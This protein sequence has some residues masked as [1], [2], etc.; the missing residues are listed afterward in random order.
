MSTFVVTNPSNGHVLREFNSDDGATIDTKLQHAKVAQVGWAKLSFEKRAKYVR[1]FQSALAKNADALAMTLTNET[2][3]PI[4]QARGEVRSTLGRIQYFLD[5]TRAFTRP[6]VVGPLSF[7][8]P[9]LASTEEWVTPCPL[10]VIANVSAWNYPYFVGTN[11]F[12]PALLTGNAV[13]YKPSEF[14]SMT[15]LAITRL[16]HEAGVPEHVFQ[17]VLG[18]GESGKALVNSNID[19]VF[20]T[21][22][23]A[24]GTAIARSLAGRCIPLQLELGGKDPTYVADD[25]DIKSAAESL[26]DGAFYNNGQ[27]CCGVERIYI[28]S[29]QYFQFRTYFLDAIAAFKMG[30]PTLADTYLGP[31]TQGQHR[32]FLDEQIADAIA[33][34]AT[35]LTGGQRVEGPGNYYA[36]TVLEGV[37]HDMSV[38]RDETF[39]PVIGLMS[40]SDDAEALGLMNDTTYGLTASVFSG[41]QTRAAAMMSQLNAG[42][43]Y[44]NCCDRVSAATPW[45]GW[46]QSGLGSTLSDE[47]IRAF[48]KP[49]AWHL[50]PPTV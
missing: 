32:R 2:G 12:I 21:G 11:V 24:T 37:T 43:V 31:L 28:H 16:M 23:H 25:A 9:G 48:L 22:S 1:N 20:F 35:V 41:S 10:G 33:K 36:P 5:E 15:G 39:G 50:R 45:T 4:S 26:A 34:G 42:T 17:L 40:V 46:N 7:Q 13:L 14:A 18:E 49:K 19:G 38:M 29:S 44:W 47:G 27:S 30:D 6:R 8:G 3:K